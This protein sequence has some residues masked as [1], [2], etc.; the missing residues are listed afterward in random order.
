MGALDIP[1][2][3]DGGVERLL[4][5]GV[6]PAAAGHRRHA[7]LPAAP[8]RAAQALLGRDVRTLG[9]RRLVVGGEPVAASRHQ[10]QRI[11]E[12]WGDADRADGRHRPGRHLLG[13]G[14]E[15]SGMHTTAPDAIIA[16]LIDPDSGEPRVRPKGHDGE[17]VYSAIHRQ[18]SPVF[19]F[20]S[21]DHVVVTGTGCARGRHQPKIRCFGR[22]DDMLIV[23]GST[24]SPARCGTSSSDA[25][26]V[27][28]GCA[29]WPTSGPARSPT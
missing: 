29:C 12:A 25:P 7:Q 5:A 6:R 26:L 22:T 1:I 9:V 11:E 23:R 21:G 10:R 2:G 14:D 24:S 4:A 17:L 8:G 27:S 16:E 20:R 3:A 19:R 15:Q 13:R 28:G 18:A